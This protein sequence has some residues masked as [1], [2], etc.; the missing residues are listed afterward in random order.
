M[1]NFVNQ[2][3]QSSHVQKQKTDEVRETLTVRITESLTATAP[4]V[5]AEPQVTTSTQVNALQTEELLTPVQIEQ[6]DTLRLQDKAQLMFEKLDARYSMPVERLVHEPN[7][8]KARRERNA[9]IKRAKVLTPAG[10]EYTTVFMDAAKQ[11]EA[12][13]DMSTPDTDMQRY[14]DR[15]K[16]NGID[17]RQLRTFMHKVTLDRDGKADPKQLERVRHA[18]LKFIEDFSSD[19]RDKQ[20]HHLD[21]ITEEMLNF[22]FSPSMFILRAWRRINV[23]EGE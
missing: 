3:A 6:Q 15:A 7:G 11:R 9:R 14:K 17:E 21:R 18:N 1:N 13:L 20:I 4:L 16:A 23:G 2:T 10:D 8:I 12:V 19:D 22:K 5:N